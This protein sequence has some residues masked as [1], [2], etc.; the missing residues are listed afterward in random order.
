[1]IVC[2][3]GVPATPEEKMQR[4]G[5]NVRKAEL[6]GLCLT[7]AEDWAYTPS[8][9]P[10]EKE[11]RTS[12]VMKDYVRCETCRR[13]YMAGYLDDHTPQGDCSFVLS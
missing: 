2:N 5:R 10:S 6:H 11:K 9:K 1:M 13:A 12:Q 4:D 7:L 8:L 3:Y